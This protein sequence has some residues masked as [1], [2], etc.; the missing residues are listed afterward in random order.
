LSF[1]IPNG[2]LVI[3]LLM[4]VNLGYGGGFSTLPALLESRFGMKNISKIHGLT[5]S[6]WAIAGLTGNNLSEVILNKSDNNYQYIIITAC[7]LY[8]VALVICYL[9]VFNKPAKKAA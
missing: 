2:V 8:A 5:L 3:I 9:L 4:I 1:G 6:A 7:V